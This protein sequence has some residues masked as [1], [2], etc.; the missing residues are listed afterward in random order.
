MYSFQKIR[1][2]ALRCIG[3]LT[4]LPGHLIIPYKNEVIR[5]LEGILDD[6]KRLVRKEAVTARGEW[7]VCVYTKMYIYICVCLYVCVYV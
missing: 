6:K 5:E 4:L 1:T 3:V 7:Y 2:N